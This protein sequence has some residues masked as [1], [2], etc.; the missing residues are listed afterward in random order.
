MLIIIW[1]PSLD[2]DFIDYDDCIEIIEE[3]FSESVNKV[4][5]GFLPE[6]MSRKKDAVAVCLRFAKAFNEVLEEYSTGDF[7]VHCERLAR[8]LRV[9]MPKRY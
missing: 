7:T 5:A 4:S 1:V 9:N 8:K 3:G 6:R 2:D